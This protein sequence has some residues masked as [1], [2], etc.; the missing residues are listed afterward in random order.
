MN[1]SMVAFEALGEVVLGPR[2]EQLGL[3]ERVDRSAQ[4]QQAVRATCRRLFWKHSAIQAAAANRCST[5]LRK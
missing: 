1:T 2:Q 4:A 5:L 3:D